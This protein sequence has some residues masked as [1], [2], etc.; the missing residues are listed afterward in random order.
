[1][2]KLLS[3]LALF[4]AFSI[5]L[6]AQISTSSPYS[7]FGLGDLDQSIFPQYNACGGALTAISSSKSINPFNPA[8][9]AS[10]GPN[11]FLLSTGGWHK[12][13]RFQNV[14]N[15][16]NA[17]NNGFSH[18]VLGF[19][20]SKEIGSSF[21]MI[22][23]SSTG[24]MINVRDNNN[25]ADINYYG[26]GG[27]SKIYF[28]GA[29]EPFEWL[30]IGLNASYLFGG[31]NRRKQLIFDDDSY[32]SSRANSKINLKG[33]YF[34]FGLLYKRILNENDKFFIGITANDNSAIR[35]NK[36]ELVETFEF[37]GTLES[38]KDTFVNSSE[39]GNINLPR[40]IST[41]ISYVKGK[42]WL[43][44]ADYTIQNWA[45]Y[46]IFNES[47]NLANSMRLSA[48]TQ[49]TPDYNSI[50]KYYKRIDYRIGASYSNTPLQFDNDQLTEMSLSF[51]F[52]IPVRKSRTKYD[53]SCS[54]GKRGKTS[55]N[56][57]KEQFFR[58]GLSVTYDGIWFIKRKYD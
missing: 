5:D 55:N 44:S 46:T 16:Q 28:G 4:I 11:T 10:F 12:T 42:K 8:S 34:E 39:W 56:L 53:F 19:P 40:F 27:I 35:A 18:F 15:K 51:G 23:Y 57:I 48:G 25:V 36:T 2:N 37:S 3:I 38:P 54:I 31:L 21:G 20:I 13:T 9:Y 14:S 32:M 45:D 33:Y 26:D 22:P 24:Y 1:M 43:F 49:Y 7:R 52:G 30:S 41:G 29:Y 47:D 17:N 58:L 6:E 50:T